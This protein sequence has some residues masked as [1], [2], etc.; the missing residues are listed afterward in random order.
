MG[1]PRPAGNWVRFARLARKL[2]SFCTFRPPAPR[3][4]GEIG[5]VLHNQHRPEMLEQ[6]NMGRVGYLG[7]PEI[8]F[9]SHNRPPNWVRFARLIPG[10]PSQSWPPASIP[11]RTG[12]IGFVSHD[13]PAQARGG[14]PQALPNPQSVIEELALFRTIGPSLGRRPPDVPSCPSLALFCI[15]MRTYRR[16]R[17]TQII[18]HQS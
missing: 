7:R 16:R 4:T 14:R 9:F 15:L 1:V 6:W 12:Q 10:V 8:G 2:G 17:P 5:F 3:P 11:G 18:N 13:R